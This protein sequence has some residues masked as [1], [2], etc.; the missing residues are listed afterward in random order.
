MPFYR[1]TI[2]TLVCLSILVLIGACVRGEAIPTRESI[3]AT[4]LPTYTPITQSTTSPSPTPTPASVLGSVWNTRAPLPEPNSETAVTQLDNKIYVLGGYPSTRKSVVT[5]QVYD[6]SED[7]WELAA[8]LPMPINHAMA[9]AFDGKVYVIGGQARAG[10]RGPFLDTVF[11]Y[12]PATDEWRPRAPM[13]TKRSSG[14]T[15][16]IDSKIYV[17]GGRPPQGHDFAV[18]DP[19]KDLWTILPELPT[20]RNHLSAAVIA[21]K[22]YVAGGRFGA[23]FRSE[24]TGA[25]EVY[26]PVTNTWTALTPMPKPRGGVNS[27]AVNGCLHVF[28]GEGSAKDP[29][30]VF[31]DHDVYN[32]LT[33]TWQSLGPMPVPVHGVTGA[34]LIDGWIHLPGGG[35]SQGGSSGSSIHQVYRAKVECHKAG[36]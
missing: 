34:A 5:V 32:P 10:G 25:L 21:G 7:R 27:I 12:D 9:A 11:E 28:G 26:D 3:S 18:Y 33:D 20:Q 23:G 19:P 29:N 16:V 36:S 17:A 8:P 31:P 35:T 1:T 13:P 14:A 2:T 15:A 24:L 4:A 6:T 30:G 22:M